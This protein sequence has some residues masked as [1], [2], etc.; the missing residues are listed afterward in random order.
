M[1]AVDCAQRGARCNAFHITT[2]SAKSTK[3][4]D[5]IGCLLTTVVAFVCF[6]VKKLIIYLKGIRTIA[7]SNMIEPLYR[8]PTAL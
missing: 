4:I 1:I 8:V 2:K 7:V 5:V 6:V 3:V